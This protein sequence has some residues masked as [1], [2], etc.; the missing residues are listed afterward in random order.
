MK[1]G[2]LW[3]IIRLYNEQ[4][5]LSFF[6]NAKFLY[7]CDRDH[8]RNLLLICCCQIENKSQGLQWVD[9]VYQDNY[10]LFFRIMVHITTIS[11]NQ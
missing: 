3:L 4:S 6:L 9:K 5:V 10:P 8:T 1:P 2:V 7:I 11:L